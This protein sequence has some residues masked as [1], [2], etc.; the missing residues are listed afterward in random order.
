MKIKK[1]RNIFMLFSLMLAL[2]GFCQSAGVRPTEIQKLEN[3][4]EQNEITEKQLN[5]FEVRGNQ[6]LN[7]LAGYLDYVSDE[8][9]NETFRKQA[10]QL[11]LELFKSPEVLFKYFEDGKVVN[12][13]I[14]K[15]LSQLLNQ[16]ESKTKLQF[17]NITKISESEK[18]DDGTYSWLVQFVAKETQDEQINSAVKVTLNVELV[19]VAKKFGADT[20]WIWEVLLGNMVGLEAVP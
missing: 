4:F 10:Q 2:D 19:K 16:E 17:I 20:K 3:T 7:D 9:I 13:T 15:Y 6:K 5:A 1:M 14:E 11:V 12:S 18:A 8:T